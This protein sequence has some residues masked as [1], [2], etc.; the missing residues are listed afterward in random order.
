MSNMIQSGIFIR[1]KV[2]GEW[3]KAVASAL[4]EK[5]PI[6][7]FSPYI[8]S[9]AACEVLESAGR[10][11]S[12]Y[13]EIDP[14]AFARKVSCLDTLQKLVKAK[15]KVYWI[16]GLHAKMMFV[17]GKMLAIGSQN[18]TN[19]GDLG[20]RFEASV[21]LTNPEALKKAQS[22]ISEWVKMAVPVDM[23]FLKKL[24]PI[25]EKMKGSFEKHKFHEQSEEAANSLKEFQDKRNKQKSGD[26]LPHSRRGMMDELL[27]QIRAKSSFVRCRVN[28]EGKLV[29]KSKDKF[30]LWKHQGSRLDRYLCFDAVTMGWGW[31]RVGKR[32]ISRIGSGLNRIYGGR[33]SWGG[34]QMGCQ[35]RAK[36]V[37]SPV[38][39]NIEIILMDYSNKQN[40]CK[41]TGILSLNDLI[42]D[43]SKAFKRTELAKLIAEK[44]RDD[45]NN[46]IKNIKNQILDCIKTPFA[47]EYKLHGVRP[48]QLFGRGEFKVSVQQ[49]GKTPILVVFR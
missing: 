36:K 5:K 18:L 6:Q 17:P 37:K 24:I 31:A 23:V 21:V 9:P 49:F 32:T 10:R 39:P 14:F 1:S 44:L 3:K 40:I 11:G 30:D 20:N 38:H 12:L 26:P 29:T 35:I 34:K 22:E 28:P 47:Y 4:T 46:N 27:K 8:T 48:A 25:V 13:T 16:K 19:Y 42:I 43:K 41:L 15:V 2:T 7:F 33:V 45:I